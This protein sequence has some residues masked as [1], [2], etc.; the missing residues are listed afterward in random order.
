MPSFFKTGLTLGAKVST[1]Q[2]ECV[3]YQRNFSP[4]TLRDRSFRGPTSEA[5][6]LFVASV[7]P[8]IFAVAKSN[9]R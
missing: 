1:E 3:R 7:N 4:F 9:C 6:I 8:F 2:L 5:F